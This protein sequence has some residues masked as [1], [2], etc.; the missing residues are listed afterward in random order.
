MNDFEKLFGEFTAVTNEEQILIR[1][2]ELISS[3][4]SVDLSVIE[5]LLQQIADNTDD[6]ESLA[7]AANA[8]LTDIELNTA[9]LESLLNDVNTNLGDILIE[10]EAQTVIMNTQTSSLTS[11]LNAIT[12]ADI[13]NVAELQA[14]QS[15]LADLLA[16]LE[17]IEANTDGL[18]AAIAL[19]EAA[20][21]NAGNNTVTE[22]QA[23][24]VQL[25]TVITQLTTMN[26]TLTSIESQFTGS[27][28]V[29]RVDI[30]GN[31][32]YVVPAGTY[33]SV[34]LIV[35]PL[36]LATVS[37]GVI[38]YPASSI[39]DDTGPNNKLHPGVTF[40]ATGAIAYLK[41]MTV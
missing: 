17:L 8:L 27:F 37:D 31:P 13:N 39:T 32:G 26:A 4:G 19:V 16:E 7:A 14:I 9:N 3:S 21:T 22:L 29:V 11:I 34:Q 40:D 30:S 10:L 36:S 12:A 2:A 41:L 20:I 28:G 1:I 25:N 23:I 18:E 5:G 35:D 15:D 24:Q 38:P 6:L 33:N